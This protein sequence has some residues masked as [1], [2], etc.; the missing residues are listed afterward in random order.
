MRRPRACVCVLVSKRAVDDCTSIVKPQ[1]AR[2]R[3]VG[4]RTRISVASPPFF[5]C[6]GIVNK[7]PVTWYHARCEGSYVHHLRLPIQLR[8]VLFDEYGSL[9]AHVFWIHGMR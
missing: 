4:P 2:R 8:S 7:L 3:S 6:S 5:A 9:H 1:L